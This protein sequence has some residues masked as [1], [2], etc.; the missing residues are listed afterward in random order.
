MPIP[1]LKAYN[2]KHQ[3]HGTWMRK[4]DQASLGVVGTV[5]EGKGHSHD[6]YIG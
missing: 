2:F 3:L 1:D 6:H 5:V 4:K